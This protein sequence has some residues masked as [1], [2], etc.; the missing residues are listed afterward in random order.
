ML[1]DQ[2]ILPKAIQKA[3]DNGWRYAWPDWV[4]SAPSLLDE[5]ETLAPL[6]IFNHDFAKALWGEEKYPRYERHVQSGNDT[7]R[8]CGKKA[9]SWGNP[10]RENCLKINDYQL[11][12][13]K[14]LQQMVIADDPIEYL[15][16][17]L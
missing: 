4:Y 9:K 13:E 15:G 5:L 11:G 12:W 3:I 7:C 2:Q 1:S 10:I 6:V 8:K 14:H 16:E 17:N